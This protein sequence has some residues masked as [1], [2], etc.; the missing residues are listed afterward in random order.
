M[1]MIT[2]L[3]DRAEQLFVGVGLLAVTLL[4]F[5]NV[6]MRYAFSSTLSWA[7]EASRYGIVWI[8]FIGASICI[9]KGSHITVDA[10]TANLSERNKRK[11]SIA[12][13]IFCIGF[14]IVFTVLSMRLTLRVFEFG[15]QSST[16]GISMLYVYG[17]MPVGGALMSLRFAQEAWGLLRGEV[18]AA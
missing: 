9:H 13:S 10:V 5:I 11:L 15:Q 17:A 8:V 14:S 2:R 16:L 6:I 12:A 18:E 1:R 3:L 4:L 7:E